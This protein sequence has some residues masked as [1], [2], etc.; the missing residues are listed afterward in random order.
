MDVSSS[1]QIATAPL[2]FLYQ[3]HEFP[4]DDDVICIAVTEGASHTPLV[5]VVIIGALAFVALLVV[6]AV[7]RRRLPTARRC[8]CGV[9]CGQPTKRSVRLHLTEATTTKMKIS[10]VESECSLMPPQGPSSAASADKEAAAAPKSPPG[11][12][13]READKRISNRDAEST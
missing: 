12:S 5:F 10:S 11:P 13:H 2:I 6:S 4:V 1:L 9:C 7:L 3:R 8:V